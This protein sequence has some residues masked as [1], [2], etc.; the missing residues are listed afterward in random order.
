MIVKL[1]VVATGVDVLLLLLLLLL[2]YLSEAP[3]LMMALLL[4]GP[5]RGGVGVYSMQ[6]VSCSI[7][8]LLSRLARVAGNCRLPLIK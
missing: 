1:I 7:V 2:L 3:V 6:A 4:Q 8:P 5:A